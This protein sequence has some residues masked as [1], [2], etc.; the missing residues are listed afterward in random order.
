MEFSVQVQSWE[1]QVY[2]KKHHYG[3]YD[4]DNM[5]TS[6][7]VIGSSRVEHNDTS[8]TSMLYRTHHI[9]NKERCMLV[10]QISFDR[11]HR[12]VITI[13]VKSIPVFHQSEIVLVRYFLVFTNER[14]L[15]KYGAVKHIQWILKQE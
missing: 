2:K 13:E 12:T 4:T 14:H 7:D 3:W 9:T 8:F 11:E 6:I 1:L 10:I 5:I 15:Q